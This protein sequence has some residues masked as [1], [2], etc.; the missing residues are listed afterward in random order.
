MTGVSGHGAVIGIGGNLIIRQEILVAGRLRRRLCLFLGRP[1][2]RGP[3]GGDLLRS[4]R[5][6][7][8]PWH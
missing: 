8:P 3:W 1:D 6:R 7:R 4:T 2:H 5:T